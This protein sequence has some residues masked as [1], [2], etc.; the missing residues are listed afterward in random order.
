MAAMH[1]Q[2][3]RPVQRLCSCRSIP[4]HFQGAVPARVRRPPAGNRNGPGCALRW[5]ARRCWAPA[6]WCSPWP[7]ARRPQRARRWCSASRPPSS[8]CTPKRPWCSPRP[9]WC[10]GRRRPCWC[11]R[12]HPRLSPTPC[13]WAA[14]GPGKAAGS[15]RPATGRRR[16]ARATCGSSPTMST[17]A[18]PSCLSTA[19]G[20]RPAWPL[21]RRPPRCA[22]RCRWPCPAWWAPWPWDPKAC[23]C[24]RR[25]ARPWA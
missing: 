16:R 20:A 10:P 24:R 5:P 15:G 17:A 13:G 21:C 9:C 11:R 19:S 7:T 23:S 25:R 3:S 4:M 22:C 8:A 14:T 6:P 12:R 1:A 2:R 18:T